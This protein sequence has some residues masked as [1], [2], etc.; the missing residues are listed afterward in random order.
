V[1]NGGTSGGALTDDLRRQ[2]EREIDETSR[3]VDEVLEIPR[4]LPD[5]TFRDELTFWQG[6]RE[7]RLFS[8]TGDATG[9]P[10]SICARRHRQVTAVVSHNV[11]EVTGSE[12]QPPR[13]C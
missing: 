9:Q 7:F 5:V 2:Q 4:V 10:C 3:F 11:T 12:S 1:T 13:R 6:A 8:T